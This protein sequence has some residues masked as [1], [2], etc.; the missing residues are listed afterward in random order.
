MS[1]A[2]RVR[3]QRRTRV[4]YHARVSGLL[5][6]AWCDFVEAA[7]ALAR[8]GERPWGWRVGDH[9]RIVG[10]GMESTER[11]ARK[12]AVALAKETGGG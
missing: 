12:A 10:Q 2:G 3:W 5:V 9:Y 7:D 8:E 6:S 1:A 4:A 11:A